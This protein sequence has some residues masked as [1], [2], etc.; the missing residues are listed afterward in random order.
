MLLETIYKPTHKDHR[1]GLN[2]R[3]WLEQTIFQNVAG[4]TFSVDGLVVGPD[5]LRVVETIT[6][7]MQG[8]A[9]QFPIE[10]RIALVRNGTPKPII[11]DAPV[12]VPAGGGRYA[13]T[14]TDLNLVLFNGEFLRFLAVFNA[15]VAA[16]ELEG[17]ATG[18]EIPRAN[19]EGG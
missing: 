13:R 11:I 18:Y 19:F 16:N 1:S 14:W 9:A 12:P 3:R 6:L 17:N 8:G 5:T 15:G 10:M 4:V 7:R 2:Q